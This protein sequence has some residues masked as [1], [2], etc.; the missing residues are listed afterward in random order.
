MNATN[1]QSLLLDKRT[2]LQRQDHSGEL[3]SNFISFC[4]A[5]EQKYDGELKR[6]TTNIN[7]FETYRRRGYKEN[8]KE[9]EKSK[10][11]HHHDRCRCFLALR[12]AQA[13][14]RNQTMSSDR[15]RRRIRSD[16]KTECSMNYSSG[17][18]SSEKD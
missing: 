13:K 6:M 2:M 15:S 4:K 16:Q 18:D 5:R 9:R 12:F 17:N 3:K 1:T 8:K 11:L 14:A 7:T 10:D